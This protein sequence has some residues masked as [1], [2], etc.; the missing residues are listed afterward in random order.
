MR[1]AAAVSNQ[2]SAISN[3]TRYRTFLPVA[4]FMVTLLGCRVSETAEQGR[5]TSQSFTAQR[6]QPVKAEL[7]SEYASIQPGGQTRVGVHFT[8]EE[9]WHIYAKA[10]GDAGLPTKVGWGGSAHVWFGPLEWPPA[11]NFIDSGDI[12]TRGY[13]GQL[14]LASTIKVGLQAAG[15]VPIAARVEWLACKDICVRGSADLE[16]T[17]PIDS[18]PP[19]LSPNAKL[20]K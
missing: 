9:G 18:S 15:A 11:E 12:R 14:V 17:L 5:V 7:I 2:Q 16:M 1:R 8:M 4:V 19:E 20:F 3:N 10:P 6:E 13:R